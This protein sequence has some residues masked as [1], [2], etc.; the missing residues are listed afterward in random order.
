MV[1]EGQPGDWSHGQ[2]EGF[3][4][5]ASGPF[6]FINEHLFC[7]RHWAGGGGAYGGWG[8]L[9]P[10]PPSRSSE[11]MRDGDCLPGVLGTGPRQPPFSEPGTPASFLGLP[12]LPGL[13]ARWPPVIITLLWEPVRA[14]SPSS[15]NPGSQFGHPRQRISG[16]GCECGSSVC[17]WSQE[18][19]LGH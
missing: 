8:A 10:C 14:Q 2:V 18:T 16:L 12:G 9:G 13:A 19:P 1:G 17:G 5:V 7:A 15:A 4:I 6:K 11:S 3:L